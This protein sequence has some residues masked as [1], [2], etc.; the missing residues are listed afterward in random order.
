MRD[1]QYP[2]QFLAPAFETSARSWG[3][4]LAECWERPRPLC[5]AEFRCQ[6]AKNATLGVPPLFRR[7]GVFFPNPSSATPTFEPS[8]RRWG[9]RLAMC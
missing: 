2:D 3:A 7:S 1:T 4:G 8:A 5:S 6:R 9:A